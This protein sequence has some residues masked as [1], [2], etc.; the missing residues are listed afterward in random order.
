MVHSVLSRE[1]LPWFKHKDN[2]SYIYRNLGDGMWWI[3][4]GAAE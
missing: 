1:G 3:D 4:F 2:E